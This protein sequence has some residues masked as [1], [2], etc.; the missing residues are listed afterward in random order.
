MPI[1]LAPEQVI[2]LCVSEKHEKYAKK[3]LNYL[4]N[5]EIR[6]FL[7][8]RKETIGKK[9]REAE[10]GKVPFMLIIG[11]KEAEMN[12]V[13]VRKHRVGDIGLMKTKNFVNLIKEEISKSISKFGS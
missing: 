5:N 11:E 3:V 9:I 1:W 6:A 13:S 8:D 12:N 2:I 10:I 7:D 4:E